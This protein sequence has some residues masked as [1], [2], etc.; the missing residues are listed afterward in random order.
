MQH[1]LNKTLNIKIVYV[2]NGAT[3]CG[4]L[5]FLE[6]KVQQMRTQS[7]ERVPWFNYDAFMEL[8]VS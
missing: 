3:F 7:P 6:G 4:V 2:I 8:A 1:A 5:H